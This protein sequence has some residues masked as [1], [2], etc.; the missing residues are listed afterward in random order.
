MKTSHILKSLAILF[1]FALIFSYT[2]SKALINDINNNWGQHKCNPFV[3]PF[4]GILGHDAT[5]NFE[6]CINIQQKFSM[7]TFLAP[8]EYALS[9]AGNLGGNLTGSI[10]KIRQMFNYLRNM[11]MKTIKTIFN[12]LL[13]IIILLILY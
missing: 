11:I 1:G 10:N 2:Q 13:S 5:K 3:M 9:L 7:G 8:I 6:Q 12:I 4:A